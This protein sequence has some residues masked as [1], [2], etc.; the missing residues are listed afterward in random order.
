MLENLAWLLPPPDDFRAQIKTLRASIADGVLDGVEARLQALSNFGLGLTQLEQLAK[1]AAAY[2]E[3]TPQ[4]GLRRIRLGLL[5]S[6]TLDIIA[7]ALAATALRHNLIL[8]RM[9]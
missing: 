6:G 7:P 3:T 4:T 1:T 2:V 9:R 8:L 5:G